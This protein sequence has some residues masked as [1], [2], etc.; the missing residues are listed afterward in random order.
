MKETH[1]ADPP[2]N[3]FETGQI[4]EELSGMTCPKGRLAW[5]IG[6]LL[7]LQSTPWVLGPFGGYIATV[8]RV[9]Y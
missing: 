4:E 6:W 9:G 7:T 8:A 2:A 1:K 5:L 3:T